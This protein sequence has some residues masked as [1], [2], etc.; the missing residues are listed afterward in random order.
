MIF[1]YMISKPK[2]VIA[3]DREELAVIQKITMDKCK[4]ILKKDK[5][6]ARWL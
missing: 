6:K 5:T 2:L 3:W 1:N 4:E